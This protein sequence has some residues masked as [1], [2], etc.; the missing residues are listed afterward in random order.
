[1][2]SRW[3]KKLRKSMLGC[4]TP[5][6]YFFSVRRRSKKLHDVSQH[7]R[8]FPK[9]GCRRSREDCSNSGLN[10]QSV[11]DWHEYVTSKTMMTESPGRPHDS[12]EREEEE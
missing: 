12:A 8:D 3:W 4:R 11:K 6:E 5:V 7:W 1:M 2:D 10:K 9:A